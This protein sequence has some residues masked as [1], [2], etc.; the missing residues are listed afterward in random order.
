L[1]PDNVGFALRLGPPHVLAVVDVVVV[2][3]PTQF[4]LGVAHHLSARCDATRCFLGG[5]VV[6]DAAVIQLLS[7]AAS[8]MQCSL[9][10]ASARRGDAEQSRAGA[11]VPAFTSSRAALQRSAATSLWSCRSNSIPSF[12]SSPPFLFLL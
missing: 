6:V 9:S 7:A 10:S 12:F 1:R 5:G 3:G 8:R 2:P 4:L 11:V